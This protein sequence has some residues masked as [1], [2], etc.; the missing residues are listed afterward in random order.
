MLFSVRIYSP[1]KWHKPPL[2]QQIIHHHIFIVTTF[3][4]WGTLF[5]PAIN[6]NLPSTVKQNDKS[7]SW[8]YSMRK[9]SRTGYWAF[10]RE[11]RGP[12][13]VMRLPHE[14]DR[15]SPYL[16]RLQLWAY[17]RPLHCLCCTGKVARLLLPRLCFTWKKQRRLPSYIK[18]WNVE[19]R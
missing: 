4:F 11:L 17:K 15:T 12:V 10:M 9:T 5:C 14:F 6:H 19:Q 7:A 1:Y 13:P 8:E 18:R 2:F 3:P 16:Q